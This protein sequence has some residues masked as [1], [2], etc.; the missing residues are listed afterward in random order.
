MAGKELKHMFKSG[1]TESRHGDTRQPWTGATSRLIPMKL[2]GTH[3]DQCNQTSRSKVNRKARKSFCH[4][5]YQKWGS[6]HRSFKI[7]DRLKNRKYLLLL[8]IA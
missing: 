3:I 1:R 6:T 2:V 8:P 5:S 4:G 7:L